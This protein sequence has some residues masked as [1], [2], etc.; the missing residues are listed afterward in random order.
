MKKYALKCII[1]Y[2]SLAKGDYNERSDIDL[3]IISDNYFRISQCIKFLS[4]IICIY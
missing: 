3:T 2:G 4:I 1:L